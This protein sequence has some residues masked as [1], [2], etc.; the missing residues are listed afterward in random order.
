MNTGLPVNQN[1]VIMSITAVYIT[2]LSR[3]I[4][5]TTTKLTV[6]E[7]KVALNPARSVCRC[8]E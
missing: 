1:T 8:W 2:A 4:L 3:I 5:R 6:P 7:L